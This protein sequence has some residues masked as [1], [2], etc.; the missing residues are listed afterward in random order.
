MNE[1]SVQYRNATP[2]DV[3][4]I[5]GLSGQLGYP[6]S[7]KLVAANLEC[8]RLSGDHLVRVACGP[9]E[10]FHCDKT[11][12]GLNSNLTDY[13]RIR[14]RMPLDRDWNFMTEDCFML[15]IAMFRRYL[16]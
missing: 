16:P 12:A 13:P 2:D 3:Q 5:A 11:G 9:D 14:D 6:V 7:E 4:G 10:K 15:N 1:L 8:M